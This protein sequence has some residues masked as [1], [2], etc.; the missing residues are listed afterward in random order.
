[1]GI[2]YY[3]MLQVRL[4]HY[5]SRT[6]RWK[7]HLV[8]KIQFSRT[9]WSLEVKRTVGFPVLATNGFWNKWCVKSTQKNPS[10]SKISFLKV[11]SSLTADQQP[12]RP[13]RSWRSIRGI[14]LPDWHR[15]PIHRSFWASSARRCIKRV[16]VSMPPRK[17]STR[18]AANSPR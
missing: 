1:M 6:I 11:K 16:F 5:C 8:K 15:S 13:T 18:W 9:G 17:R 12:K 10:A 7:S 14:G 2:Q 3:F 4:L